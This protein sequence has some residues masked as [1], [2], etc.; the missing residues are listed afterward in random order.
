MLSDVGMFQPHKNDRS[1]FTTA[2][3]NVRCHIGRGHSG[4]AANGGGAPSS[5]RGRLGGTNSGTDNSIKYVLSFIGF[6]P[7]LAEIQWRFCVNDD[8]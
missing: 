1:F 5:G 3:K 4:S 2:S 7:F 6:S 8:R